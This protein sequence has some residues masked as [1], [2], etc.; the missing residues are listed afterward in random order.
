VTASPWLAVALREGGSRQGYI[1]GCPSRRS[2]LWVVRYETP[3]TQNM[4]DLAGLLLAQFFI[5]IV[6]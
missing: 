1:D 4:H 5:W 2:L 3:G 6:L